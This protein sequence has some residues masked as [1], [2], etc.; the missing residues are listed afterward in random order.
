M[1][2]KTAARAG[3]EY[4]FALALDLQI[5]IYWLAMLDM[6]L[7]PAYCLYNVVQK[8]ALSLVEVPI[9][10]ADGLKI[11]VDANGERVMTKQGK[12]RQT[13][14]T[15]DGYRVKGRT[16]TYAEHSRRTH[17]YIMA[18]PD[19]FLMRQEPTRNQGDLIAANEEVK[20]IMRKTQLCEM[21]REWPRN[22]SACNQYGHM[23]PY[24]NFCVINTLNPQGDNFETLKNPHTELEE[25]GSGVLA[26]EGGSS[27]GNLGKTE[28]PL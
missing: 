20:Q 10:D 1:E 28:W 15:E 5:S 7:E 13:A 16:E 18:T 12:P 2:H 22:K 3:D 21:Y 6:G 25:E 11:V 24:F 19:K 23:C 8:P 14:S 17:D 26:Q 4:F 9:L 27:V